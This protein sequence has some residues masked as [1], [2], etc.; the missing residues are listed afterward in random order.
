MTNLTIGNNVTNI[1]SHA[2]YVCSGLTTVDIPD[3]VTTIGREAFSMC[4]N[5][6]AVT[7]GSG[8]TNIG[9]YGQ[10]TY[11]FYSCGKLNSVTIKAVTPPEV[12]TGAF[13]GIGSNY[14]IYVPSQSVNAR[15]L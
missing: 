15:F 12:G 3:S 5:L 8:C 7:I 9:T 10:Y 11:T 6:T 2:F 14:V 1:G 4:R 13:T